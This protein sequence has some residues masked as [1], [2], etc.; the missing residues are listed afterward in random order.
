MRAHAHTFIELGDFHSPQI[1][2][3][4]TLQVFFVEVYIV[5]PVWGGLSCKVHKF[6]L[7]L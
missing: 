2:A 1:T 4:C 6:N 7:S 3:L 5:L